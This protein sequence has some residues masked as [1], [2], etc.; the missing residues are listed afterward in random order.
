M[1]V[2]RC[3]IPFCCQRHLKYF[4]VTMDFVKNLIMTHMVGGRG[5]VICAIK[6]HCVRKSICDSPLNRLTMQL[7][8]IRTEKLLRLTFTEKN[9]ESLKN[10][11]WSFWPTCW[12]SRGSSLSY[13]NLI[14]KKQCIKT[15]AEKA[16]A[17]KK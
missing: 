17:F 9:S 14:K 13:V 2:Q 1:F 16:K 12:E 7:I 8:S 10:N 5:H 15:I 11:W 6:T 3:N 4:I